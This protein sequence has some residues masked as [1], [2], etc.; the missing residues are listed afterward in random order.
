MVYYV[1]DQHSELVLLL[2]ERKYSYLRHLFED[3]EE[4]KENIRASKGVCMQAY[5]E[6]LHVH[7]QENCQ[8]VSD[9]EQEE[10]EYKSNLEQQQD[11]RY[12]SHLESD[13]SIFA[14]FSTDG[15]ACQSY[16]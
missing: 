9:S 8:Y 6:K 15:N 3:V 13:S 10:N 7:E 2:I 12:D 16:G 1:M 14:D 4:V 11:D 5:L